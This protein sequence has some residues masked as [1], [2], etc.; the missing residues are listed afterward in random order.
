MLRFC[1]CILFLQAEDL[2]AKKKVIFS[3]PATIWWT[4]TAEAWSENLRGTKPA[5]GHCLDMSL[6]Y[7]NEQT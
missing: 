1:G 5:A 3:G 6:L 4:T 7:K 2:W